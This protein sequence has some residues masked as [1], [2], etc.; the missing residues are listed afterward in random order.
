MGKFFAFILAIIALASA[1]PI[2]THMYVQPVNISTHGHA[3]DKELS[4]TMAAAGLSFVLAQL[5]L[6]F[7]VWR[8]SSRNDDAKVF[9]LK[10]GAKVMVA[11]AF[12]LVG[13]EVLAL[14]MLGQK[15]WA[16]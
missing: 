15:T 6:A 8:F 2:V 7:F 12:I 5:L 13:T 4:D 11:A 3:I 14:G 10:N 16:G 9:H 1:Y